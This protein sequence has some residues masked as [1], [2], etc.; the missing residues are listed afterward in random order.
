MSAEIPEK[1]LDAFKVLD[2]DLT[3]SLIEALGPVAG[4]LGDREQA[5]LERLANGI[6]T[7]AKPAELN[8]FVRLLPVTVSRAVQPV[9]EPVIPA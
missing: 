3:A 9:L 7:N 8:A 2:D 4:E 6:A 1:V 5:V